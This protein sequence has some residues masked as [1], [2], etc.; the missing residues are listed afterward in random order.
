MTVNDKS[1]GDLN[2]LTSRM[3]N[4]FGVLLHESEYIKEK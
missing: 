4:T 2:L 1:N 3:T